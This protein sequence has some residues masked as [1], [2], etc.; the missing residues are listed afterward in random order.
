[1][2]LNV[3]FWQW[4]APPRALKTT[5]IQ[6]EL[7]VFLIFGPL[8]LTFNHRFTFSLS[9]PLSLSLRLACCWMS[10]CVG[11]WRTLVSVAADGCH[12]NLGLHI[13]PGIP[14]QW[15]TL[16]LTSW[17]CACT[18]THTHTY[19][20]SAYT[21]T[22]T[23]TLSCRG[24]LFL[25]SF[26]IFLKINK[27][28]KFKKVVPLIISIFFFLSLPP[29]HQSTKVHFWAMTVPLRH[30]LQQPVSVVLNEASWILFSLSNT[31]EFSHFSSSPATYYITLLSSQ[32]NQ[33]SL[34]QSALCQTIN[35]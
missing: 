16:S 20:Y 9:L 1:M 27:W 34:C 24:V 3:H 10:H 29:S 32:G 25:G 6:S 13:L 12:S 31:F 5:I 22:R 35:S 17:R 8:S 19:L 30:Q 26:F 2:R 15:N 14:T 23:H 21:H 4:N 7:C 11:C 18:Q 33:L 28:I